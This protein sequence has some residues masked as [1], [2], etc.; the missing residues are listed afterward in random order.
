MSGFTRKDLKH[1]KFVEEVGHQYAYFTSH[2]KVIVGGA[3]LVIAAIVGLS[4]WMSY[5]S[6]RS[7]DARQALQEAVRLF[8]GT[9]TTEQRT[10]Y[11]TYATTGERYRRTGE[12]LEKVR[13]EYSGT[14]E[15][16]GA[17]YYLGLLDIEQGKGEEAVSKLQEASSG[18]GP[19]ASLA[20]LTL[21]QQLGRMGRIDEA[22]EQFQRLIDNPSEVVS[23]DR[24]KLELGRLLAEHDP[25]AA[26]TVLESLIETSSPASAPATTVLRD[27]NSGA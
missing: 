13:L 2:R 1:D 18:S 10:G 22:R 16:R 9:V 8:H 14:E 3:V 4:S 12:A 5:R 20:R 25:E 11:I 7:S 15:A 17:Q 27:L 26:K 21:A 6:A 24:A 23:A 19:Y